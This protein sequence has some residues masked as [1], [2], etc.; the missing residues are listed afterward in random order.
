MCVGEGNPGSC[1]RCF[2]PSYM[3]HKHGAPF[4]NQQH[5][6]RRLVRAAVMFW[7][8]PRSC[9]FPLYLCVYLCQ[10][11]VTRDSLCQRHGQGIYQGAPVL[12][13]GS[14]LAAGRRRSRRIGTANPFPGSQETVVAY[15]VIDT[16]YTLSLPTRS[17]CI[18]RVSGGRPH[19]DLGGRRWAAAAMLQNKSFVKKTKKGQVVKVS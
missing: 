11:P 7:G 14:G 12:Q 8:A 3:L 16:T 2:C 15:A 17:P 9:P 18:A 4:P 5:Q 10:A 19:D 6:H 13:Q 1:T